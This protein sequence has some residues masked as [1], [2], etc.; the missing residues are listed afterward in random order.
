V[1][2]AAKEYSSCSG[3]SFTEAQVDSIV[4]S[5]KLED[6]NV[7]NK[8]LAK[9]S[10][11]YNPE[12]PDIKICNLG[13]CRYNS[14]IRVL[15]LENDLFAAVEG[16]EPVKSVGDIPIDLIKILGGITHHLQDACS[17]PHVVPI[18]HGLTDG[19]ENYLST[20]ASTSNGACGSKYSIK[21]PLFPLMN[22]T[23]EAT[24]HMVNYNE[25]HYKS[26][27]EVK[28]G[29]WSLFWKESAEPTTF[30]SYGTFGNE[31][32]SETFTDVDSNS[33]SVPLT[34]Q[35]A[36]KA[37]LLRQAVD[38]TIEIFSW[39][40]AQVQVGGETTSYRPITI[41]KLRKEAQ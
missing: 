12:K 8:W 19:Y 32:G 5:N 22:D 6:I 40:L 21:Q 29:A 10:H 3:N 16:M 41:N 28:I 11:Y 34:S 15:D 35:Q 7:I 31:F 39:F 33:I 38:V 1:R 37:T 2:L 18:E 20:T 36:L 23:A 24:L 9:Y 25:F 14:T 26:G 17:P 4:S 13:Y 30:G 27:D